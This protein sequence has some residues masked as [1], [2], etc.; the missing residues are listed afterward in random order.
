MQ[1]LIKLI[2][3]FGSVLLLCLTN[4]KVIKGL[5]KLD[6]VFEDF[7]RWFFASSQR[8]SRCLILRNERLV[9]INWVRLLECYID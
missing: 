8:L 4:I 5:P 2:H 6:V 1:V 3:D 9:H 7:M